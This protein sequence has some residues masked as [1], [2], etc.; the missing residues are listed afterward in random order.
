VAKPQSVTSLDISPEQERRTRFIKYAI[1]MTIRVICLL[2]GVV[3]KG[4]F[5]WVCFAGAILL[6]YF[7]VVLANAQ[8]SSSRR[9]STAEA[10]IAQ[11]IQISADA[12]KDAAQ[13][14]QD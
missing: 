12:F 11:P 2:L 5:M 8:G 4:W 6:P 9:T 14:T 1:A 10:P 13:A 3:V 7:A